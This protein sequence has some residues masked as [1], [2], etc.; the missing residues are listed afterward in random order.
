MSQMPPLMERAG[1]FLK[2]SFIGRVEDG[3]DGF[4]KPR[5]L[6]EWGKSFKYVV[7]DYL[8]SRAKIIFSINE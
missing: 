7:F 6:E 5:S 2:A 4:K 1:A 3:Y 8:D